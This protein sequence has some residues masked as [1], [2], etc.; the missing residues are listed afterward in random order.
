MFNVFIADDSKV[1]RER[2][3]SNISVM[4]G[5]TVVGLAEN[6]IEADKCIPCLHPD[7]AILDIRMPLRSGIEVLERLRRD[8]VDVIIMI[9]T[10]YP[11]PPYREK[12]LEA[13]ANF[14]LD[15]STETDKV[16]TII[17]QLAKNV[18]SANELCIGDK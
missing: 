13:G 6:G 5:V 1:V 2:L 15:K 9:L 4:S 11:G 10:N 16:Y 17:E 12:C 14:F 7:L 3:V 18:D 8:N